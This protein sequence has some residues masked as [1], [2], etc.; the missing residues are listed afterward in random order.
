MSTVETYFNVTG[1]KCDGCITK[2]RE[3]LANVPGFVE[4]DFDL[5]AGTAVIRGNVDPEAVA[6][7]LTNAGYPAKVKSR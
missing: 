3:A 4:A 6:Q 5:K 1:M 7:A 2:A